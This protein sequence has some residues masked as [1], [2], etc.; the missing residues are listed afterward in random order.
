MDFGI[1]GKAALVCAG[2]RGIGRACAEVLSAEGARVAVCARDEETL[3]RAA[4]EISAKTGN[5]VLAVRADLTRGEEIDDLFARIAADFGTLH[6]LVNNAGR[7][8]ASGF[9]GASDE[10]WTRSFHL[11]FLSAARCIRHGLPWMTAQKFGRVVNLVSFSVKQPIDNLIQSTA[12]R[13]AVVGMAKSL[14]RE[15]AE[16]NVTVNNICPG[17][18]LTERLKALIERRAAENQVSV[19]EAM[20]AGIAEIPAGRFGTPGEVAAL[21]AFLASEQASYITGATI[22]VDG[23]LIRGLL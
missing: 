17:Y 22:Q 3:S 20:A 18:V 12:I 21:V 11:N 23:G 2:S 10:D 4:A 15:V 16:H 5:P 13:S 7:P 8:A 9:L 6:I 19:E 14:S 1:R